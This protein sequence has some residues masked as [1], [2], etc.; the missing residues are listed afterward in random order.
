YFDDP[1]AVMQTAGALE[2]TAYELGVDS[3]ADGVD[4]LEVRW[5]PLLHL[6]SGLTVEAVIEAVLSGLTAAP[7]RAV[8]IVCA[9]RH[10]A[11][12]DN[13]A[14][15]RVAGRYAGLGVVG[16]DLAGDEARWPALPQ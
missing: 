2:R 9:M 16:F 4:Y 8:A 15:A 5:A 7:L 14:L 6:R 10:H 12:A 1:I 13:V 3:A 11:A